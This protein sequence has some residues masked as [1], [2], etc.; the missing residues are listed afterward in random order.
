MKLGTELFFEGL[1]EPGSSV[2]GANRRLLPSSAARASER[3]YLRTRVDT[4][5]DV[6][7]VETEKRRTLDIHVR[8]GGG[9]GRTGACSTS[10]YCLGSGFGGGDG[11]GWV[12]VGMEN[13]SAGRTGR[14]GRRG[15]DEVVAADG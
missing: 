9:G 11:R 13:S 10:G 2:I 15:G 12:V 5:E 4:V 7:L 6:A 1:Q 8:S 3:L 14:S